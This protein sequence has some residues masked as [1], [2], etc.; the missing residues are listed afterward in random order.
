M[1]SGR[2]YGR[3]H[4]RRGRRRLNTLMRIRFERTGGFGNVPLRAEIDSAQLP[5]DRARE[6]ER[7]VETAR[8]FDQ[9][10]QPQSSA[11]VSD[12][13][14]YEIT[15]EEGGRTH[16]IRTSDA[17]ASDDLKLLFDFLGEEALRTLRQ[18]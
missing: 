2:Y 9:P 12:D 16:T 14:Q 6:L 8:P 18:T 15:I 17:A 5:L 4:T 13:F 3:W 1:G 10:P 7:L 11:P